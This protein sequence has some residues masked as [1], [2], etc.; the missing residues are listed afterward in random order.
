MK[1]ISERT[2]SKDLGSLVEE[3][4]ES[5]V[6]VVIE[7]E[8]GHSAVVISRD[9]YDEGFDNGMDET[10]YLLSSPENAR[11]LLA[12]VEDVKNGRNLRER[13]LIEE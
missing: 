5:R 2:A 3:V 10:E 6:P 12:A 13:E 9:E 7:L 11:F 8:N 4:W 1:T